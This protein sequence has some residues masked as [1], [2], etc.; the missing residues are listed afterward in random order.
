M[1]KNIKFIKPTEKYITSFNETVDAV[2]KEINI[3]QM[4]PTFLCKLLKIL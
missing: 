3:Y 1:F 4:I 2:A